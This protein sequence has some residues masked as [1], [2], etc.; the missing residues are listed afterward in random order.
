MW[1]ECCRIDSL[2]FPEPNV[3]IPTD[4]TLLPIENDVGK[5]PVVIHDTSVVR[6][7][8]KQDTDYM[9]PKTIM[10]FDFTSPLAYSDPLNCNLTHMF[11]HLFRDQL[12]EY[13]YT[14]ELAGLRL[15]V[16]NTANGISVSIL[17]L[18]FVFDTVI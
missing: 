7:W 17:I 3:F 6:V 1:S 2:Q 4:F 12:N 11:V 18:L 10:H 8:H 9:K 15:G 13:L 5:F 16:A 14:A